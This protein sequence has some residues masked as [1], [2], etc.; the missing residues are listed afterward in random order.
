MLNLKNI[1]IIIN[2]VKWIKKKEVP[3]KILEEYNINP[4]IKKHMVRVSNYTEILADLMCLNKSEI[5]E[6]KKGALLH[7]IGKQNIPD[8]LLNKFTKLDDEEFEEVKKHTQFG[9]KIL[10]SK[11]Y[12]K[13]RIENIVLLHHEK[14]NGDGY[15]FGI[16]GK[17]IPIEAR[18]VSV[19]DCYDALTS[20]RVY[21]EKISHEKAMEILISE[22]GKSFDP[23]IISMFELFQNRFKKKLKEHI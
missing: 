13:T 9:L 8:E 19:T 5:E 2:K 11:N 23:D 7:D 21:K 1:L 4:E 6:I 3:Y 22:S 12:A 20:D 16:K 10:N 17:L 14:W 18:I 15:P